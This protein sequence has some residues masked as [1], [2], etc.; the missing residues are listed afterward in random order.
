MTE[1]DANAELLTD[2][3]KLRR[4][5]EWFDNYDDNHKFVGDREVQRDLR[6]IAEQN[7][8]RVQSS[9]HEQEMRDVLT[10]LLRCYDGDDEIGIVE[11][12][13]AWQRARE[14]LSQ[15]AHDDAQP[16]AESTNELRQC[17]VVRDG[18]PCVLERDHDSECD[19]PPLCKCGEPIYHWIHTRN[20]HFVAAESEQ[21]EKK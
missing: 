13:A 11:W 19:T 10:E 16:S 20:H 5:A 21:R 2:A 18:R 7:D 12:R 3:E 14:V 6:R 9:A 8:R 4:L 15:S 17:W 1:I